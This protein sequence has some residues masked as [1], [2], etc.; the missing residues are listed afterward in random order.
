M[1]PMFSGKTTELLQLYRQS[2][3]DGHQA[4]L[5]KHSSDTRYHG[6]TQV[7]SHRNSRETAVSTHLLGDPE[8]APLVRDS[9]H[10]FIDEGQFFP[11]LSPVADD[12]ANQGKRVFVAALDGTFQREPFPSV[13]ALVPKVDAITKLLAKCHTCEAPAPFSKRISADQEV[14]VI[15]GVDKYQ[16]ACRE[17]FFSPSA[18]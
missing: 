3:Q 1:G 4:L 2:V 15:G 11:D 5:I 7:V 6:Q 12:Y 13:A 16:A 8:L 9:T 10:I 17:H 14:H 18:V